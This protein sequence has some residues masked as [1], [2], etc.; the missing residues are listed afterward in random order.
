MIGISS[1]KAFHRLCAA[2][3]RP[4]WSDDPRFRTNLDRVRHA[5]VL[6]QLISEVLQSHPVAH[7]SEILD[8]HDVANDPVQNPEQVLADRQLAAVGQLAAIALGHE[9]SALLPGLPIGL[10]MNPPAI[11]GPPPA[12][13]EH[14]RAILREAGYEPAE[15]EE[16]LRL[17]VC[18]ESE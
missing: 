14:T 18:S 1:D 15:I 10:S 13:G 11:Q 12:V 17:G 3:E 9:G 8:Q 5:D 16:L 6:E 4:D 7:W 2:L